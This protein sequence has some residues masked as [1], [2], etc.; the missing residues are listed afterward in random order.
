MLPQTQKNL[1]DPLTYDLL[2]FCL[3]VQRF[4]LRFDL[5]YIRVLIYMLINSF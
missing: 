5:G 3:R 1:F 4:Y 2:K